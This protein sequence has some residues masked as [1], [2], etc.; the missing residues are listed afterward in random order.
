M[1]GAAVAL[2]AFLRPPWRFRRRGG[3]A[4]QPEAP[5][6]GGA[7]RRFRAAALWVISMGFRLGFAVWS[8]HSSGEAHL[9]SFSVAHDIT[10]GQ[11]GV[12]ALILMA[13]GEVLVRLGT[14]AVRARILS[15]RAVQT[16]AR[17]PVMAGRS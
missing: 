8:S 9:S 14:I 10:S 17:K 4:P 7:L 3:D 15:A 12:T 5:E 2:A 11:A 13:F 6:L 1:K 16:S